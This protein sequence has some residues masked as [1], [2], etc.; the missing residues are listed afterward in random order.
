[1]FVVAVIV[2]QGEGCEVCEVCEGCEGRE[3]CNKGNDDPMDDCCCVVVGARVGKELILISG[4]I[5]RWLG[6]DKL[7]SE[8]RPPVLLAL[9]ELAVDHA[10]LGVLSIFA[11][12]FVGFGVAVSQAFQEA[13]LELDVIALPRTKRSKSDR[14]FSTSVPPFAVSIIPNKLELLFL[15]LP[16][17]FEEESDCSFFVC[18]CSTFEER[19]FIK[20]MKRPNCWTLSRGPRLKFHN[21][22]MTS[23][24]MN[25]VSTIWP[26]C[27][28]TFKAAIMT[29]GSFVLMAFSKGT[30]LSWT[31]Y[32]SRIE[33]EPDLVCWG[34][35]EAP[36]KSPSKVEGS[37]FTDPPHK[38]TNASR[39]RTLMA[40]LLVLLKT[41]AMGGKTSSFTVEKSR[42]GSIT[43]R[44]RIEASTSEWVLDSNPRR[45]KGST[46]SE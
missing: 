21:V 40:R 6:P 4:V 12:W 36:G 24:A 45:T 1:M 20:S 18:C 10:N 26:T 33:V 17:S 8:L 3:G 42:I 22:G 38:I 46:S 13:L 29:A 31:V 25:S 23:R 35:L 44:H 14:V 39:P 7:A 34:L 30:I 15:G 5:D 11:G 37:S 27:R 19:D 43:G 28:N 2:D 9:T 32:L 16:E 41:A